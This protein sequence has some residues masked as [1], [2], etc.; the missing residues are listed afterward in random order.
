MSPHTTSTPRFLD[1]VRPGRTHWL[2]L[3][4]HRTS[5][6]VARH[7]T[8]A[9]L[10]SW[11]VPDEVCANAVLLVSELVTNAVLH[12]PGEWVLCGVGRM[13]AERFR[14]EVHDGDLTGRGIPD[15]CPGLD[16]E[17]GRGLLLVREI[18][19]SWGVTRSPLTGG[20]AVWASLATA[21]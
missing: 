2:E 7:A 21:L 9:R 14:L 11:Q 5:V 17:G 19:D 16:D 18:A 12:T 4:S 3:P 15:R 20:N 8:Q 10:A 1:A 13:T 6:R